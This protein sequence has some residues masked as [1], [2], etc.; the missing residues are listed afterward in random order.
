MYAH[1][2]DDGEKQPLLS[3]LEN[4]AEL[5]SCFAAKFRFPN[6][7][8]LLGLLHD[9][10]KASEA[11]QAYLLSATGRLD[12][13]ADDYVDAQKLKGKIDHSTAGAQ[14]CWFNDSAGPQKLID[15]LCRQII[16]LCL[17]SHHSGLIDSL[18]PDGSCVFSARMDKS[19]DKTHRTE[20]LQSMGP[21][22]VGRVSS[23]LVEQVIPELRQRVAGLAKSSSNNCRAK[24]SEARISSPFCAGCGI[25]ECRVANP[26]WHLYVGLLT[27]LLFSCL[28]DADR[29]DSADF[30]N[31]DNTRVRSCVPT[32]WLL[33][34][35]RLE[36]HLTAVAATAN[37]SELAESASSINRI[38]NEISAHCL[39]RSKDPRGIF[40]L[41]VPTG[42]GKTLAGLRFAIQHAA[43]HKMARVINVIPYT[44]II[45]QNAR[46]ARNILEREE[47]FGTVVLEHHSNIEPELETWQ[48]RL[49]SENWDAPIIYTTMVQ[50]LESLFGGGTRGARRMHRLANS[51]IVFDEIQTLPLKCVHLFCNAVNFL[52]RECDATVV[53]CTATQPLL[54]KLP[55]P[56]LGALALS[57][58]NEIMPEVEHLYRSLKRVEIVNRTRPQGWS[59]AEVAE[60][61]T[62]E[63]KD[64]GSC[65]VIVNTKKWARRVYEECSGSG[66]EYLFHLSTSLCPA[67]RLEHLEVIRER[68]KHNRCFPEARKPVLCVSTQ[69]IE[70]G[71][72][73]DFASVV[74]FVAGLDSI[75]Q[76]AGRCNRNG[77]D[78]SGVVHIVNPLNEDLGR[79]PEIKEG[80]DQSLRIL[81]EVEREAAFDG[82]LLGPA[83]M[84]R[85]FE[86][87]FFN[88]S[89]EMAYQ[90]KSEEAERDDTLLNILSCNPKNTGSTGKVPALRQSFATAGR[91]FEVIDGH[92]RG[93]IVPYG[94]GRTI[95]NSLCRQNDP[96][97]Q[98]RLLRQAQLYTVNVF[99]EMMRKLYDQHA[100]HEIRKDSGVFYLTDGYY[101]NNFGLS[102]E[103]VGAAAPCM[104]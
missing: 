24:Q 39:A 91:L 90:I 27:R 44:S 98:R 62:Q 51:V 48:S 26:L 47:P 86:Y 7:G 85:Y 37:R 1:L 42:G 63:C 23:L 53:L 41:T 82:D 94:Q 74:R 52:V 57:P 33:L 13:D 6:T 15:P 104:V 72:D 71:V 67:H 46:V 56:H 87:F 75:V 8:E 96:A 40:T 58:E 101:D 5:A 22:F 35:N 9:L 79:L 32:D 97:T 55:H 3:H 25:P 83:V 54:G 66:V 12:Q 100:V 69:L 77:L 50:F 49:L 19:E 17:C 92:A 80:R 68:L 11:F 76:A 102:V 21:E 99:P 78:S 81:G 89:G 45:D 70:A 16:A 20:V 43:H 29:I 64:K 31:P 84:E 73:V 38:R 4:V 36:N 34:I 61:A 59:A 10:G 18:K 14:W 93:I 88:R 95:I 103:P 60:L 65:L 2:R 30:D 28:L